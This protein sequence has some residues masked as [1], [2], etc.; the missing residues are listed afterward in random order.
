MKLKD[1]VI[2]EPFPEKFDVKKW[3]SNEK[4]EKHLKTHKTSVMNG[5][6]SPRVEGATM[7]MKRKTPALVAKR[8]NRSTTLVSDGD[9]DTPL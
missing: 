8:E 4:F 7:G 2:D 1:P 5:N 6:R 3:E 9:Y